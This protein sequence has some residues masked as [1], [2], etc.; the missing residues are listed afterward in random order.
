MQFKMLQNTKQLQ[1]CLTILV[2]MSPKDAYYLKQWVHI[3]GCPQEN[4]SGGRLGVA[5]RAMRHRRVV[6]EG[7]EG[8]CSL[9]LETSPGKCSLFTRP[10]GVHNQKKILIFFLGSTG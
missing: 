6:G 7:V 5:K 8:D 3:Q 9:L 2:V 1:S 10:W 4:Q